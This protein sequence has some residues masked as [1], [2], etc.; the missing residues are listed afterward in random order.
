METQ[1]V[2]R[3]LLR[4]RYRSLFQVP[5]QSMFQVEKN[6]T[7]Q[8]LAHFCIKSMESFLSPQQKLLIKCAGVSAG[9]TEVKKQAMR[10]SLFKGEGVTSLSYSAINRSCGSSLEVH[11][12]EMR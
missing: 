1:V 4:Q 9:E 8:L 2:F 11:V 12:T 7:Y 5:S 6:E 10:N 3:S